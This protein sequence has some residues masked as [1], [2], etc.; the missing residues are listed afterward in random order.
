LA[1]EPIKLARGDL[2]DPAEAED[3]AHVIGL[4]P[5]LVLQC[6]EHESAIR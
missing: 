2:Q 6:A 3:V 5:L 4:P 1:E